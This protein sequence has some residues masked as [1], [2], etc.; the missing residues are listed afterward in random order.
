MSKRRFHPHAPRPATALGA[1][2]LGV[3]LMAP[4]AVAQAPTPYKMTA[5]DTAH[6]DR[7]FHLLWPEGAPGAVGNEAVDRPKITVY[8]APADKATGAAV[9]VCPGGGYVVL[10][11][12]HEGR[13]VAEWLNS[14]GVSAF[15][16]QYR[17]GPRYHHPAPLQD[18][19]RALRMVR[20]RAAEWGVDPTKV[21][22][23]GF[24]A[25]G[26]LASTA[27]THFDEGQPGADDPVE[28]MGSRPDF[29]VLCYPVITLEGPYAHVGS[30]TALLGESPDPALV[31]A[32]SN[33]RQV[34][35]RTP[36]TFL[37]H[38]ADDASVPVENS[39]LFFSALRK[40]GVAAEL[41]IFPH[42]KHGVGL[43][44]GDPSLSQWPGLCAQWMRGLG[45]L[46]R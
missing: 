42:G 20:S 46:T 24:S 41:H 10:A 34:T 37:F 33:Q 19:Q 38:T 12:D 22:I 1:L 2:A 39:L 30:R 3:G 23:L 36:P 31:E 27:A 32:L 25:G 40:A 45:L 4:S 9:V 8:R 14:L 16:L 26:H 6:G 21:G 44:P 13:Q 11:A 17:L 5:V 43:A 29:A 35:S 18:A 15:V 7:E 28:R